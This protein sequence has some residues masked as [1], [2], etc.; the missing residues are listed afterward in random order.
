MYFVLYQDCKWYTTLHNYERHTDVRG[1]TILE[2]KI[3]HDFVYSQ[4]IAFTNHSITRPGNIVKK[5][6]IHEI[7]RH[8][9]LIHGNAKIC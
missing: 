6:N 1:Q 8:K 5:E 3:I 9:F 7:A 2:K 4:A